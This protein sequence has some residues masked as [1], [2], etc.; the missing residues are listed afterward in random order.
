MLQQPLVSVVMPCLNEEA[1]IGSCIEKILTTFRKAGINGEIVVCDNGSTDKSVEIAKSMGVTV[2]HQP[3]RGYGNAYLKGFANARGKYFIMGDADDTYDF[4]LIPHFLNALIYDGYDFVTGSRFLG[5]KGLENNPWLHRL[6]GN[7]A[8]TGILNVLFGTKY[9]DVYCG[10]RG[11]SREA[12]NMIEPVSPGMEFNLE[13]AINAGLARLKVKEIPIQLA[14]R[15]GESKLRTLRDGWRSVRMMLL[16]S[17]NQL[18][19]YPGLFLLILGMLTHFVVLAELWKYEGR[20]LGVV[21]GIF[22]TIF[23]VVGFEILSLGLNAKTYSWS[24]RFD[25]DNPLLRKFYK[26]FKLETGLLMGGS[27]ILSG[28]MILLSII[29]K[30]IQSNLM[31]LPFPEWSAFGATLVIIGFETV[32]SSLFIST[33]SMRRV[34]AYGQPQ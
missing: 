5:K 13:L 30:W 31:P 25:C 9:T 11:F 10:F 19:I 15:K 2:I 14:P 8:I 29:S 24:R 23:S 3:Q 18:F 34:E 33:M 26:L 21:T 20:T 22:A 4:R 6:I 32:F 28:S 17:P 27:M 1:G 7:P 12:Y 16:Y